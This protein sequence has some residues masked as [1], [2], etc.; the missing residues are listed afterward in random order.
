VHAQEMQA[1]HARELIRGFI[2]PLKLYSSAANASAVQAMSDSK[3]R[4]IAMELL[5]QVRKSMILTG[6]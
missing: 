1:S 3:L 2:V 6:P 4:I 5:A